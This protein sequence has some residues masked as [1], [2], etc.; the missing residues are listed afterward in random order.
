M[1]SLFFSTE[2]LRDLAVDLPRD[3]TKWAKDTPYL[4]NTPPRTLVIEYLKG[5]V[6]RK[7]REDGSEVVNVMP[8]AYG[9]IR[10]TTD[11]HGEDLDVYINQS[12]TFNPDAQ[13]YIIDQVGTNN[14]FDEHKVMIGFPSAESAQAIYL[15]VC[16]PGIAPVKIGAVTSMNHEEFFEWVSRSD[17]TMSPASFDRE[18]ATPLVVKCQILPKTPASPS[19]GKPKTTPIPGGAEVKLA[20]I[21]TGPVIVTKSNGEKGTHYACHLYG[22]VSY[23]EWWGFLDKIVRL[24]DTA[25]E[26]DKFSLSISSPGG[27]VATVGPLLAAMDSTLA[28]VVTYAEGPVASA[29]VF[30]WAWG[31]ER[32]IKDNAYFMEHSTFQISIGKT[33][34]IQA[35]TAF[36]DAYAR[37]ML[38]RL[39]KIGMFTQDEIEKMLTV[40]ADVF[41]TADEMRDRLASVEG[42]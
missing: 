31:K 8:A 37:R 15:D 35:V 26:D 42:N 19:I 21:P 14:V 11:V 20:A 36:T 4:F 29:A 2:G 38:D 28:H 41:I 6:R 12:D 16:I 22:P 23:N 18:Y 9:R 24:M 33:Q 32:V 39:E 34:Y 27:S 3:P 30:V 1:T 40:G 17:K 25:T 5:D 7:V 10:Q 13:V